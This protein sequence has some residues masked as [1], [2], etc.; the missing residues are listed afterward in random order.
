MSKCIKC[1]EEKTDIM[2]DEFYDVLRVRCLRCKH[3][4]LDKPENKK[5]KEK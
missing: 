4:W 3:Q 2:Y 1:G 5:D